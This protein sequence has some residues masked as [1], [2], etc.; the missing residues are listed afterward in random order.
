MI[1]I[2]LDGDFDAGVSVD[3]TELRDKLAENGIQTN[4]TTLSV[5]GAKADLLIGIA[6]VSATASTISMIINVVNF[7]RGQRAG[8]YR[9]SFETENGAVELGD[10]ASKAV[11]EAAA[12]GRLTAIRIEKA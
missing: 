2:T 1:R 6:I 3:L 8:K 5:P 9:I 7:W 12:A 10:T 4:A 11:T